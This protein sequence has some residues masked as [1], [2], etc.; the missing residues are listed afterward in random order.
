MAKNANLKRTYT[1]K[2]K[3]KSHHLP[4]GIPKTM[5]AKAT[6][7]TSTFSIKRCL[8]YSL[9]KKII[10]V[11]IFLVKINYLQLYYQYIDMSDVSIKIHNVIR[12]FGML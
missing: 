11:V 12:N 6:L 7:C 10:C 8:I 5:E 4:Q 2:F 3:P 1:L 9:S